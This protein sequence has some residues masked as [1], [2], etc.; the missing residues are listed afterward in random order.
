MRIFLKSYYKKTCSII[1][2]Y[3]IATPKINIAYL[4]KY[5]NEEN[6]N[7]EGF[8]CYSIICNNIQL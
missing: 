1:F 2:N 3:Y 6:L 8:S 4:K 7:H 5:G